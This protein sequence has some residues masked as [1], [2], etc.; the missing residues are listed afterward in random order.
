MRKGKR[1]SQNGEVILKLSLKQA[2][3]LFFFFNR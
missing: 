1:T 2:C 3:W